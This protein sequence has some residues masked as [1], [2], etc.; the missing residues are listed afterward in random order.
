MLLGYETYMCDCNLEDLSCDLDHLEKLFKEHNPS[1]FILVSPL[2][3][4]PDMKRVVD[5]CKKYVAVTKVRRR[6]RDWGA[7]SFS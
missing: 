6:A 7:K 4:V 2:G 3:L 1:T 5:L